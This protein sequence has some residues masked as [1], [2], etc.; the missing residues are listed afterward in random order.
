MAAQTGGRP[1][2]AKAFL[3]G[4]V[5]LGFLSQSRGFLSAPRPRRSW[6]AVQ[7][8]LASLFPQPGRAG[9]ALA[10]SP[11][12][13]VRPETGLPLYAYDLPDKIGLEERNRAAYA[14]DPG[15]LGL[16]AEFASQ[17]GVKVASGEAPEG[18][19]KR[20]RNTV[21]RSRQKVLKYSLGEEEDFM[22]AL[23]KET[24]DDESEI[25]KHCW[26][27]VLKG[28][29]GEKSAIMQITMPEEL[30]GELRQPMEDLLQSFRLGG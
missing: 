8:L 19:V 29:V 10:P 1:L 17:Q 6:I 5:L 15:L 12:R 20:R 11:S 30:I 22:E 3:G 23:V 26:W 28:K 13:V 9:E 14:R 18:F 21:P 4:L 2:K 16:A 25:L 27:R 24:Q 7:P